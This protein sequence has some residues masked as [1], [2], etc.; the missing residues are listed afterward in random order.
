M[1]VVV[2]VDDFLVVLVY[3][4]GGSDGNVWGKNG[5]CGDVCGGRFSLMGVLM[6][7]ERGGSDGDVCGGIRM[8]VVVV[9]G[10][11]VSGG[12]FGG[13]EVGVL[14]SVGE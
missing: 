10:V 4:L 5:G 9:V 8:A 13:G 7:L 12:R 2:L 1:V 14:M 6:V 11:M 3:W